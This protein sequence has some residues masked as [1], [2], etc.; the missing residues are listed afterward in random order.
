MSRAKG[1][2]HLHMATRKKYYVVWK[3][4]QPGVYESWDQCQKQVAGFPGAQYK[5]FA[6]RAAAEKA[7][8]QLYEAHK[9]R[10]TS[11]L[12]PA[13][14]QDQGVILDSICVDAACSGNPGVL[15]YQGVETAS[16]VPVFHQGPFPEGTIN[17]GEFLAIVHALALLHQQGRECPVYSDSEVAIGW[18]GRRVVKTKLPRNA[19]NA[20][21][22]EFVD[23]ALRWLVEHRYPNEIVKWQTDAWGEIL[24][25]F[26]RK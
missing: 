18:V 23:R 15:E 16:G 24:A 12:S 9:G 17:I 4:Q 11:R 3:G 8:G 14:L 13:E 7:L 19:T 25:D 1:Q 5:S 6:S 10:I 20:K 2:L 21:L 22:F 26:D